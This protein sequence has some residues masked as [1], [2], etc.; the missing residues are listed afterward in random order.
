MFGLLNPDDTFYQTIYSLDFQLGFAFWLLILTLIFILGPAHS[1]CPRTKK[2]GNSFKELEFC[3]YCIAGFHSVIVAFGSVASCMDLFGYGVARTWKPFLIM[4]LAYFVVDT[5]F[6]L[7]AYKKLCLFGP[8]FLYV[9]WTN[10]Q[11]FSVQSNSMV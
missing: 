10:Q 6:F 8:S 5:F 3:S 4:S 7:L 2:G 9:F 1:L 11:L